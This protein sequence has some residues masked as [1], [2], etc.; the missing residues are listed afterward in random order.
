MC[1]ASSAYR[2]DKVR[3]I[4]GRRLA[5]RKREGANAGLAVVKSAA[6][7]AG[8]CWLLGGC[9]ANVR[10]IEC[11]PPCY[12]D[13]EGDGLST[14]LVHGLRNIERFVKEVGDGSLE[15]PP[16]TFYVTEA[17][18]PGNDARRVS[19]LC[20]SP[21]ASVVVDESL[22]VELARSVVLAP[23]VYKLGI[24][25]VQS[26]RLARLGLSRATG[27][28]FALL[29][30]C[31]INVSLAESICAMPALEGIS[32]NN[33]TIED[34]ALD[35]LVGKLHSRLKVLCIRQ[36]SPMSLD[37]I[38][39]ISRLRAL[40]VLAVPLSSGEHIEVLSRIA[41]L[42][43]MFVS[44][45]VLSASRDVAVRQMAARPLLHIKCDE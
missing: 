33:C 16:S 12:D 21:G 13:S 30:N 29:K 1:A 22:P 2:C 23:Q 5:K 10:Q 8:L 25:G 27:V 18:S 37:A 3:A 24:V 39:S 31:V 14:P 17:T 20:D 45:E 19:R 4:A 41:T 11:G 35:V 40:S 43:E 7:V 44:C 6:W 32:L 26:D 34:A 9:G 38:R 36:G 42:R 28:R 15:L